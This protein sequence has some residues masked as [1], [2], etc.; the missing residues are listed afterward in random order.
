M[1]SEKLLTSGGTIAPSRGWVLVLASHTN[2]RNLLLRT[3]SLAGYAVLGCATLNEAEPIL[4]RLALPGLILFDEMEASEEVLAQR[5]QQLSA[6]LPPKAGCP[7]LILSAMHPLPRSQ[8][9]PGVV[10][11]VAKPFNLAQVL[12][13]VASYMSR[14]EE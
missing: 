10:R 12:H 14:L 5:L 3:L 7:L 4:R 2:L 8:S 6:L 9:L 1:T 11:V 13:L